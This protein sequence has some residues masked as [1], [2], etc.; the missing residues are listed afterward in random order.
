MPCIEP[1]DT[2]DTGGGA[3]DT[4]IW[5]RVVTWSLNRRFTQILRCQIN[6]DTTGRD[7]QL[8]TWDLPRLLDKYKPSTRTTKTRVWTKA[9]ARSWAR[10]ADKVAISAT[11]FRERKLPRPF[12]L[13]QAC[14]RSRMTGVNCKTMLCPRHTCCKQKKRGSEEIHVFVL[15]APGIVCKSRAAA[16]ER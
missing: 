14:P 13:S 7:G 11:K 4:S 9:R 2:T 16:T 6:T 1:A 12:V 8:K 10:S 15:G 3:S 5:P